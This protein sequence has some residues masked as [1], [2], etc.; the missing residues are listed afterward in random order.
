[1]C[2]GLLASE[3]HSEISVAD[4]IFWFSMTKDIS[5]FLMVDVKTKHLK[6]VVSTLLKIEM[7]RV[8]LLC[9]YFIQKSLPRHKEWT[10]VKW[11]NICRF[12]TNYKGQTH[13]RCNVF[14]PRKYWSHTHIFQHLPKWFPYFLCSWWTF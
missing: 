10:K 9:I 3:A 12:T 7:R 11:I 6:Q 13:C 8:C 2:Q 5:I 4:F 14:I 1:M